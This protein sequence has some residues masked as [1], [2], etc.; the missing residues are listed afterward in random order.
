MVDRVR[1][2]ALW[3]VCQSPSLHPVTGKER[4]RESKI[5]AE[6]RAEEVRV[7]IVENWKVPTAAT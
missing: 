2:G 3:C 7:Q 5:M 6:R 1:A 4:K